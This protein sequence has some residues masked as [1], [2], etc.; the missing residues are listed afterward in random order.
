MRHVS[1]TAVERKELSSAYTDR[2]NYAQVREDPLLE[3]EALRLSSD[4]TVIAIS[5]GGCTALSLLAAGAGRVVAVDI[6]RAQN[7]LVELKLAAIL[8]LPDAEVVAFVGGSAAT[9]EQRLH[10]YRRLRG[11]LSSAAQEYWDA[12]VEQI[13]RGIIEAGVTEGFVRSV[14]TALRTAVHSEGTIRRLL[15][16]KSVEEQREF[17]DQVWN[18]WR[19]KLSFPLLLNRWVF[20]RVYTPDYFRYMNDPRFSA[21][22][23]ERAEHTLTE[24][25]VANNYFLHQ[26]LDGRY[27]LEVEGG[28]PPYLSGVGMEAIRSNADCL[29]LVDGSYTEYLCGC[30][31]ESV[32]AFVISNICE[33][34]PPEGVE[35]VFAQIARVAAPGARLCFRNFVG[36]TEVPEHRRSV[37]VEDRALGG[38]LMRVDRSVVQRRFAYC[39]IRK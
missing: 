14:V 35:E 33:W 20:D 31:G 3:I 7:H 9:S 24:I 4:D 38:R 32:S 21:H 17:Y 36:W 26:M 34:L 39:E 1:P 18:N 37:I 23:R 25:G 6:N 30:A 27:L 8:R 10:L 29:T 15:S 16:L 12:R 28:V 22:F 11:S 2:L 13:G 5:S 19:W